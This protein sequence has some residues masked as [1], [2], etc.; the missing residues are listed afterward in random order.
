MLQSEV[1][2]LH[3]ALIERIPDRDTKPLK[4]FSTFAEGNRTRLG[5]IRTDAEAVKKRIGSLQGR[6]LDL[7]RR[8]NFPA[9]PPR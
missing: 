4:A 9:Q 5:A 7:E 2:H 8:I 1:R 3:D 6:V